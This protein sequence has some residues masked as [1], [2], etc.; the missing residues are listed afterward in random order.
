[1]ICEST[2]PV[3]SSASPA[4][5]RVSRRRFVWARVAWVLSALP[6]SAL[7]QPAQR[8]VQ[9]PQPAVSATRLEKAI[10]DLVNRE[11]RAKGLEP[12]ASDRALADVARSHSGD[13]T[14]RTYFSHQSPEGEGFTARYA[15][16]RY[17]CALRIGETVHL[18]AENLAQG[19]L[20]ASVTTVNGV[21][22]FDWNPEAQIAGAAVAGWMQSPGHRANLLARQW[23]HEGIGVAVAP[24]RKVYVTQNFC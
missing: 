7:A 17:Q 8:L 15:R 5:R 13:M 23:R 3:K 22:T 9:K 24:D 12:L 16:A 10:H 2:I 4:L 19:N 20:F 14:R 6:G 21:Q 18:G 1:L 11:R